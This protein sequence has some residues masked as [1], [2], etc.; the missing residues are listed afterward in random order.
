VHALLLGGAV[1]VWAVLH[2]W[3][4]TTRV[5]HSVAQSVGSEAARAYRLVYNVVSVV[6]FV[7]VAWL[8][9]SLPDRPL[10]EIPTP[11]A[12]GMRAI[13]VAAVVLAAVTLFQT[14]AFAFAG[15]SQILG[16]TDNAGLSTTGFYRVV[17]HPLY[18]F[19]LIFIWLAPS[20]TLNQLVVT[21]VFS[22]YF[23]VGAVL[24]ERRLVQ[25]FGEAYITY[26]AKTPMILP[27]LRRRP[28]T[29]PDN[30]AEDGRTQ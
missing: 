21:I 13:Q 30:R 9:W 15:L 26:R 6:S 2:S 8:L 1:V 12:I 4:A 27:R 24:E 11:W 22:G 28:R 10:Y 18:L 25:E 14:G 29:H 23:F 5:K 19:G 3:L 17:R 7:P 16:E 20:M